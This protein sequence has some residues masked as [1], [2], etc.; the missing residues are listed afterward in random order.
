MIDATGATAGAPGTFTPD[1]ATAPD[2]G[3]PGMLTLFADP[4]TAWESGDYVAAGDGTEWFWDGEA[5]AEGRA[6]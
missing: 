1:G 6:P 3:N 5:W 4:A 2:T